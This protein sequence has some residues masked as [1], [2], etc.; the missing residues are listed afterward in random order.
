[1]ATPIVSGIASYLATVEGTTNPTT[2]KQV[3]QCIAS[4][5][6]LNDTKTKSNLLTYHDYKD[7]TR[8]TCEWVSEKYPELMKSVKTETDIISK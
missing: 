7:Y 4:Y 5:D 3:L 1:M 2:I 8:A 6:V